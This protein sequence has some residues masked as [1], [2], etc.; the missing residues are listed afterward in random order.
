MKVFTEKSKTSVRDWTKVE[1]RKGDINKFMDTVMGYKSTIV[2]G[3]GAITILVIIFLVSTF[4]DFPFPYD[5]HTA[6]L[7]QKAL[8]EHS[9]LIKDTTYNLKLHLQ[10]ID[11]KMVLLTR[12]SATTSDTGIDLTDEKAVTKQCLRIYENA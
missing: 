8:E 12:E 1:F 7:S 6:K 11:D 4:T 9:E 3:L 2:V 5:R 10:C